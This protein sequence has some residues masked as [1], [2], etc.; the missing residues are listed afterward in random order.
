MKNGDQKA[1]SFMC[2][3][4]ECHLNEVDDQLH[5]DP[6]ALAKAYQKIAYFQSGD[7]LEVDSTKITTRYV[8][9]SKHK[10]LDQS[11]LDHL[12]ESMKNVGHGKKIIT[13]KTT[14]Q[15][16]KPDGTLSSLGYSKRSLSK[17]SCETKV[18]NQLDMLPQFNAF[19]MGIIICKFC[20]CIM[21]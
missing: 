6:E 15:S 16:E 18:I 5:L 11:E 4:Q 1:K 14:V 20:N 21:S 2:D 19:I 9:R 13:S 8:V 10:L 3:D 7:K 17:E 12:P